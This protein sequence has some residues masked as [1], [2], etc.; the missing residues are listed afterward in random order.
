[1]SEI[2]VASRYAKSL[3]DLGLEKSALEVIKAD[4][5]TFAAT[6]KASSELKSVLANPIISLAKKSELLKALFAGK[7]SDTTAKF[8]DMMI[9]KNR[10]ELLYATANEFQTQ[11][12][13][14]KNIVTAKVVSAV[15]LT[16]A[17]KSEIEAKVKAVTGGEVILS[18]K[19]DEKLIGGFVLT[20]GDRQFDASIATKLN[21]LKKDFSRRAVG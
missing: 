6:V 13:A 20:V 16:D 1:M 4:M 18:T 5:E 15:P 3:I 10:S 19:V 9:E 8:F 7:V 11:Y 12:H 17:L 2:K 21:R 14:L